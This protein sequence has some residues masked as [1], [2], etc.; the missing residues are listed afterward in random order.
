M[1]RSEI[2]TLLAEGV[3]TVTFTKVSGEL[4]SMPCT[5]KADLVPP[6]KAEQP[7]TQ[8]KVREINE[9]VV[10]AFCTDKKEWRSFRVA[11]VI[12]IKPFEETV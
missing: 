10:V 5:L 1:T 3:Y 2:L 12:E 6:P 9:N 8:K 7:E 11:N 4:R